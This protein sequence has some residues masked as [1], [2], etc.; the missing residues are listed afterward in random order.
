MFWS[1]ASE[2]LRP[3][4]GG[5][6]GGGGPRPPP[7]YMAAELNRFVRVRPGPEGPTAAGAA[8]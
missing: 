2:G 5:G 8:E 1:V 6:G 4:R 7:L 3:P